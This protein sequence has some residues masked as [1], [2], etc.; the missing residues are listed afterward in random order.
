MGFWSLPP[1]TL[2]SAG[3]STGARVSARHGTVIGV[4]TKRGALAVYMLFGMCACSANRKA[5]APETTGGGASSTSTSGG[6]G[7]VVAASVVV[8]PRSTRALTGGTVQFTAIVT[9]INDT[10]VTWSVQE[11]STGGTVSSTG[12]FKASNTVGEYHVIATSNANPAVSGSAAVTVSALAS[13]MPGVWQNVTPPGIDLAV[14][15]FNHDGYGVQDVVVDPAKPSNLYAFICHQGAWR[16]TDYGLTWTKVNTGMNAAKIDAGKPW[17]VAIDPNPARNP[18]TPPTLYTAAGAS[19]LLGAHKSIDGGVNWTHYDIVP[20]ANYQVQ[21]IYSFDIDPY[22][23]SH[24]ITGYHEAP[25]LAESTD[26][27][28]TWKVINVAGHSNY[29]FFIDTRNPATTRTTWLIISQDQVGTQ[30]TTDGGKTWTTVEKFSH[31]HG[32]A[33]IF[34]AGGGVIYSGGGGGS[35]GGG[36]YRSADYGATWTN[37]ASGGDENAVVATASYIYVSFAWAAGNSFVDPRVQRAPKDPGTAWTAMTV[38]R[39]MSNGWKRAA[40]TFDG[41]HYILVGGNWNAGIWRYVEP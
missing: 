12:A 27:G 34:Q 2:R 24:L 13:A 31:A 29:P 7:S 17:T 21:D 1:L 15:S 32:G 14:S 35:K 39:E 4:G 8:T 20:G 6:G 22:D 5:A 18:A 30:R 3:A 25:N 41:T 19:A 38:P 33:Q 16:S 23:S 11:G 40:V 9:G 36:V 37:V 10:S 26:G 28:A